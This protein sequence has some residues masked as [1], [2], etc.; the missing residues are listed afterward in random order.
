[1]EGNYSGLGFNS[2][3]DPFNFDTVGTRRR[4]SRLGF[5]LAVY[6]IA[7]IG[8]ISLSQFI[9]LLAFGEVEA[10]KV[11]SSD[12]YIWGSQIVSMYVVAFPILYLL[13]RRVPRKVRPKRKMDI[14]ELFMLFFIMQVVAMVGSLI[15]S[16]ISGF[17]ELILGRDVSGGV[18]ELIMNTPIW[19]V[20]LVAVVIG[21]IFEELIF[22]WVLIDRLSPYGEKFAIVTSA[23]AFGLFHGNFDQLVYATGIGIILGYIYS[24]TRDIRYPI[25]FHIAFNF[26]GSVPAMLISDSIN[27]IAK[28]PEE[29]LMNPEALMNYMP[30]LMAVY[31]YSIVQ[32]AFVGLGVYFLVKAKKQN[33]FPLLNEVDVRIPKGNLVRVL[34]NPGVIAFLLVCIAQFILNML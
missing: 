9:I 28:I 4:F 12:L 25:V 1:M 34:A 8:I 3:P 18:D 2:T 14:E 26:F 31:G 32:L 22:R 33:R 24:V 5:S 16:I 7:A 29:D 6:L 30:D 27:N 10:E 20:I 21:P 13:A 23:V 19:I 15:S 17:F 11:F